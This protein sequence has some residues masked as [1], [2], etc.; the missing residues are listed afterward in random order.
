MFEQMFLL[1]SFSSSNKTATRPPARSPH[2]GQEVGVS[3]E[4][5]IMPLESPTTRRPAR[6]KERE[7][8]GKT[9]DGTISRLVKTNKPYKRIVPIENEV[10]KP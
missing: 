3:G 9:K 4:T 7:I 10:K 5:P 1:S 6:V 2:D 8:F